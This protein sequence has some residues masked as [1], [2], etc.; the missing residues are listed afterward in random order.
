[1]EP[2]LYPRF[3]LTF[4]RSGGIIPLVSL[5]KD[6]R[7]L[8]PIFYDSAGKERVIDFTKGLGSRTSKEIL[9]SWDLHDG[10]TSISMSNCG[11]D[12]NERD[13]FQEHNLNYQ[14][15]NCFICGAV[16]QKYVYE[17]LRVR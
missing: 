8:L 4:V 16:A 14:P 6:Y 1:M 17:L 15:L 5:P 10:L 9:L 12:L 2:E 13:E 7:S 3:E 11:L